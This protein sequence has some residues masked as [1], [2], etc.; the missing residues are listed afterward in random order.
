[1]LSAAQTAPRCA[2]STTRT[3]STS[4][5]PD[6]MHPSTPTLRR[7]VDQA[8]TP[9]ALPRAESRL[10]GQRL[11]RSDRRAAQIVVY[12]SWQI[13]DHAGIDRT[14][15]PTC[16]HSCN[17]SWSHHCNAASPSYSWT[18]SGTS[19][20]TRRRTAGPSS[21]QSRRATR[22]KPEHILSRR[23][24]HVQIHAPAHDRRHQPV[25]VHAHRPRHLRGARVEKRDRRRERREEIMLKHKASAT[26][27]SASSPT[28][29][30]SAVTTCSTPRASGAPGA[31]T[32][33]SARGSRS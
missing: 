2:T 31:A 28:T 19:T 27:A 3:T 11:R 17:G 23:A 7:P 13:A 29:R 1:M 25:V 16:P 14:A 20:R 22:S 5:R 9:S 18:T 33:R 26:D 12:D 6:R 24:G 30:R 21:T 32:P 8:G 15:T 10:A 4:P